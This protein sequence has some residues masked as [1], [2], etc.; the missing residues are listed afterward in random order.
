MRKKLKNLQYLPG[1]EATDGEF[2]QTGKLLLKDMTDGELTLNFNWS[3]SG[4]IL[5]RDRQ[6]TLTLL[7]L[8]SWGN[9]G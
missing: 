4:A 6:F 5:S 2:A 9:C 1:L 8:L 3:I 7:Y